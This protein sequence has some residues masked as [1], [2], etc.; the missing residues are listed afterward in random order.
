VLNPHG[1]PRGN[2]IEA[3]REKYIGRLEEFF[4]VLIDLTK[5]KN[6]NMR[7]RATAEIL[8]RL[9]GRPQVTI[10]AQVARLDVGAEYLA[11]LRRA[12]PNGGPVIDAD[13]GNSNSAGVANKI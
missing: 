9:I 11:A 3:L 13:D 7:L 8:D 10:D 1:R 4:E 6:E 5:S 12:Y 2:G